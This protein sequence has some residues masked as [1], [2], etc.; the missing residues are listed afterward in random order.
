MSKLAFILDIVLAVLFVILL[1][2]KLT[3][4]IH[5]S[6]WIVTLPIWLPALVVLSCIVLIYIGVVW[7]T[8]MR[9]RPL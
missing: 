1:G 7:D 3:G 2:G 8:L 9:R 4:N 6:W 5:S